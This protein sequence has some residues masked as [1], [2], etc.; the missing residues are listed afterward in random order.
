MEVLGNETEGVVR[1]EAVS[2]I[3]AIYNYQTIPPGCF[4]IIFSVMAHCAVSDFHWEVRANALEFWA[5]VI[6]RQFAHQGM[7]NGTFPAVTFSKEHKK[8]ITLNDK[9]IQLRLRK[10]L[11]E[12][13]VRGCLGVLMASL[14]DTELDVIKKTVVIIEKMTGYLNKYNFI[15]EYNRISVNATS[16]SKKPVI[17]SNYS[18]FQNL[19]S[20][21]NV[22]VRNTADTRRRTDV[23]LSRENGEL[24]TCSAMDAII[25]QILQS[26]D[27]TLLTNT[28]KQNLKVTCKAPDMGKIDENLYKKFASVSA[29]DFLN[30]I[31]NHN[32]Q[33]LTRNKSEWL[34]FSE[35]FSSL[36]D[37][38]LRSSGCDVDLDCY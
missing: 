16:N 31:T 14:Q 30:Y 5:L 12:L 22:E 3:T 36:L 2:C 6:Q 34:Q 10:V 29:D 27:I 35:T 20:P 37:D 18:E 9:E 26:D 19:D 25:D 38:V 13:S 21:K 23:C 7:I 17:D 1:R 28:Y 24:F 11:N 32:L 15:E 4:D 33:Q 8:I